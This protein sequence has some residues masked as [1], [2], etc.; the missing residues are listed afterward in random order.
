MREIKLLRT[1]HM[2]LVDDEDYEW[3]QRFDWLLAGANT[4]TQ[5]ARS[6]GH[7]GIFMHHMILPYQSPLVT[8]HKDLNGLNNQR[9][10]LTRVTRLENAQYMKQSSAN[11]SGITGVHYNV[12]DRKWVAHITGKHGRT[13]RS[14][15]TKEAAIEARIQNV[16]NDN[17]A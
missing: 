17:N 14:F 7:H 13:T 6:S 10:N 4:P 15:A 3:L 2:A 5:Y 9:H 1:N 8:H 16:K 11:T 12:R